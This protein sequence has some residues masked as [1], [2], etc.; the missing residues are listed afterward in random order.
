MID[1]NDIDVVVKRYDKLRFFIVRFVYEKDYWCHYALSF[2]D[3]K[4]ELDAL[5]QAKGKI[6]QVLYEL[7]RQ[8]RE[9]WHTDIT[10]TQE[11][12]D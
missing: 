2:D 4:D 11:Y 10:E 1:A 7:N 5:M 6:E 12:Q 9:A 3:C 8:R